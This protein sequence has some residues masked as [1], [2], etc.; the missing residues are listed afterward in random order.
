M[1]MAGIVTG[2]GTLT[3]GMVIAGITGGGGTVTGV[4]V[5]VGQAA[6]ALF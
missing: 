6:I 1:V 3:G 5:I 2:G 4:M